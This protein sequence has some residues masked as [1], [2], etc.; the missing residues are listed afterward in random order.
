MVKIRPHRSGSGMHCRPVTLFHLGLNRSIPL[1]CQYEAKVTRVNA[2]YVLQNL[3]S[4]NVVISELIIQ[5][6]EG[7]GG[8]LH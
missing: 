3:Y 5:Q 1:H 4:F 2:K 8:I 6:R 7:G